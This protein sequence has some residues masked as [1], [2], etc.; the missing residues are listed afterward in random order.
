MMQ[1]FYESEIEPMK[2]KDITTMTKGEAITERDRLDK[3]VAS[4]QCK[5]ENVEGRYEALRDRLII[6]SWDAREW[7]D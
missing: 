3:M 1:S 5:F 7:I 6:L 2:K 4:G